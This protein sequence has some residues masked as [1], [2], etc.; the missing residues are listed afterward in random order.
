MPFRK[1][2]VNVRTAARYCPFRNREN[3]YFDAPGNWCWL[4]DEAKP[5][6]CPQ[7]PRSQK[8]KAAPRGC[9]LRK[10]MVIVSGIVAATEIDPKQEGPV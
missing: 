4:A 1:V 8:S 5:L 9:P 10:G 3:V 6:K 7:N 2:Q